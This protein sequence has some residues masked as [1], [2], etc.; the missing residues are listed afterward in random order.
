MQIHK[1]VIA[2]DHPIFLKGL[3]NCLEEGDVRVLGAY[4]NGKEAL[5]TI[6][7]LQPDVAVLDIS[8]PKMNGLEVAEKLQFEQC[9]T[10]IVLLSMYALKGY[11]A[12]AKEL[13]VAGYLLKDKP[14]PGILYAVKSV[15]AGSTYF[16]ESLEVEYREEISPLLHRLSRLTPSEKKILASLGQGMKIREIAE[17]FMISPRTVEKHRENINRKLDL[18]FTEKSEL[19]MWAIENHYLLE[20]I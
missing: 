15:L 8:M 12:R 17:A 11:I 5:E 20:I 10:A 4:T 2:D 13:K 7:S 9:S 14:N 16:E 19:R 6:L 18:N 1:A 3:R